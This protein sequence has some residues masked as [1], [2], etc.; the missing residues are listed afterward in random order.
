MHNSWKLPS[1]DATDDA[2]GEQH[3]RC[4]QANRETGTVI[5]MAGLEIRELTRRRVNGLP[6]IAGTARKPLVSTPTVC[7]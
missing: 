3:L 1:M 5:T 4:V 7:A 6:T 2:L